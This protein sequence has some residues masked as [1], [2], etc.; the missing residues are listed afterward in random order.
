ME[1]AFLWTLIHSLWIGVIAAALTAASILCTKRSSPRLRYLLFCSFFGLFVIATIGVGYY[2]FASAKEGLAIGS[3]EQA[4]LYTAVVEAPGEIVA[5]VDFTGKITAFINQY[6]RWIFAA[7]IIFFC[8]KMIKFAG[9]LFHVNKLRKGASSDCPGEWEE[10]MFFLA[11]KL[12]IKKGVKLLQ[13]D[14]IKMPLTIGFFKPVVLLPAGLF[15]QL[16]PAYI[17]SIVL[18]EL[19]H[20]RRH[21]YLVNLFQKLIEAIFFFNPALL[22]ISQ[23]IREEREAC[24]DDLVL[25]NVKQKTNYLNALLSFGKTEMPS[26]KLALTLGWNRNEFKNRLYRMVGMGNQQLTFREGLMLLAGVVLLSVFSV[27]AQEPDQKISTKSKIAKLKS[28]NRKIT[29]QVVEQQVATRKQLSKT[30]V[31]ADRAKPASKEE[32][33]EAIAP[34]TAEPID[35]AQYKLSKVQQADVENKLLNQKG[36]KNEPFDNSK[37][38]ADV[39][40]IKAVI[41]VLVSEGVVQNTASVDWFGLSDTEL[42]VNGQ[43]QPAALHEKLKAQTQ[44]SPGYGLYY[45]PVKMVGQGFF[46]D[47]QELAKL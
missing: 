41:Q 47:K 2:E 9:G 30:P 33:K 27:L 4:G 16:P 38:M 34:A 43:K 40:K 37:I 23:L 35:W 17:E 3:Q 45:G 26:A 31:K 14:K 29:K 18:H 20:I 25:A 42:I 11:E 46:L 28:A 13:S 5:G 32:E 8:W 36:K 44:V 10:K 22:W 19:A 15:L 1:I 21:D 7:W 24:C 6:A 12:G 39:L